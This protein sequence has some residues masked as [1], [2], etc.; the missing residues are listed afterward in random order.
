ML[1]DFPK[2]KTEIK[3]KYLMKVFREGRLEDT[4]L[5]RVKSYLQHEGQGGSYQTVDGAVKLKDFEKFEN[6]Y[7]ITVEDVVEKPFEEILDKFYKMGN[8]VASVMAK[9]SF[10]KIGEAVDEVGNSIDAAGKPWS[11]ELFLEAID[12]ITI[13]FDLETGKPELPTIY[14]HPDQ[15]ESVKKMISVAEADEEHKK[16]FEV[17]IERKRGEWRD[18]EAARKLVD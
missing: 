9:Y 11:P 1:P 5:S 8:E 13:D 6:N 10:R 7:E 18:R 15:A 4:L 3:Q 12:K 16:K 14:I 2:L 17:I